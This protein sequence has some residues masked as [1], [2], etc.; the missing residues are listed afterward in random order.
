M[1]LHNLEPF[2]I[3][4]YK[5]KQDILFYSSNSIVKYSNVLKD[6]VYSELSN[7]IVKDN[8]IK[9]I[10]GFNYVIIFHI[11]PTDFKEKSSGRGGQNLIIGYIIRKRELIINFDV[12]IFEIETF[13]E[14]VKMCT[15]KNNV[16][17]D[18]LQNVNNGNDIC[19]VEKLDYC[20]K[21]IYSILR[22]NYHC[23]DLMKNKNKVYFLHTKKIKISKITQADSIYRL[24]CVYKYILN[25]SILNKEFWILV[26][27]KDV[28]YYDLRNVHLINFIEN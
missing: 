4:P 28:F 22:G 15:K 14:S 1:I 26:D 5:D 3:L 21:E 23:F 17:T 11:Y 16:P 18:F 12:I 2:I 25:Q 24:R 6:I 10:V 13:F 9:V 19:I 27:C 8:L 7:K 20:I